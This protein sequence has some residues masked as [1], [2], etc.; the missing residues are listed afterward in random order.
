MRWDDRNCGDSG[1]QGAISKG[2]CNAMRSN[3]MRKDSTFRRHGTRLTSSQELVA[4]KRM[5]RAFCLWAQPL[6]RSV[7]DYVE[8]CVYIYICVL[9]TIYILYLHIL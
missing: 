3:E 9:Q 8:M 6:L 4:A 2:S 7:E 5:R 1:M